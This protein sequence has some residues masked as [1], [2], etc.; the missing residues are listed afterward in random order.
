MPVYLQVRN[1]GQI[2]LPSPIRR[3]ANIAEGD[4]LEAVVDPDGTIRL[5][6]KQALDRSLAEKYQLDDIAWAEKRKDKKA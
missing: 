1:N 6:P 5:V 3:E 4:L 2:T